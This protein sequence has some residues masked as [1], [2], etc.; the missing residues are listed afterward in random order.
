MAET[1]RGQEYYQNMYQANNSRQI[2]GGYWK[3]IFKLFN[4]YLN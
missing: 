1:Q 2:A 4:L 3:I